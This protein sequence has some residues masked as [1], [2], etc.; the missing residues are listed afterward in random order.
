[1]R[2]VA[3]RAG[4]SVATVSYVLTGAR[5]VADSTRQR[6]EAAISD[7]QYQPNRLAQGLARNRV[8][9]VAVVLPERR[10]VADPLFA[11]F[12]HGVGDGA[13]DRGFHL[14]L[15]SERNLPTPD[16]YARLVRGR[17]AAGLVV[18]SVRVED[19]RLKHL[20]H[21]GVPTVI[22]GRSRAFP[23]LPWVDIDNATAV[24][25]AVRHLVSGGWVRVAFL[26]GPPGF[27]FAAERLQGYMRGLDDC[28]LPVEQDLVREGSL[29]EET[30]YR[31]TRELFAAQSPDALVAASDEVALGAMRA[32]RELGLRPGR[33][34]AL[35]GFDDTPLARASQP[36]LT[37]VVQPMYEAGRQA[38]ASLIDL[39][40]GAADRPKGVLLAAALMPR[41]S[42]ARRAQ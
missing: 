15:A 18:T 33:D 2:D 41:A 24:Q 12:V 8:D 10:S 5:P 29:T 21:L 6:I 1:M 20:A 34:V 17:V 14:L 3:R 16:S 7:L 22:F 32:I 11:G 28:G 27:S 26:G 36:A 4:V 25:E 40:E 38:A 9:T 35:V 42:S 23:D 13:H 19:V 37:S 31:Q 39:L 30:G